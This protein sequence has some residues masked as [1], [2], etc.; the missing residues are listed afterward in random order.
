MHHV[1]VE[2][3]FLS[4]ILPPVIL[5]RVALT[6]VGIVLRHILFGAPF[7]ATSMI[8]FLAVAGIVG[9]SSILLVCFIR[10][11]RRRTR[12]CATGCWGPARFAASRLCE[13][14]RG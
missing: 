4:V 6:L 12:A 13:R 1:L 2:G 11:A 3:Q 5:T 14:R 9:H 7:T 10:D 8:G